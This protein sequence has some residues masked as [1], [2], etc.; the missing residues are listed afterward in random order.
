MANLSKYEKLLEQLQQREA[1]EAFVLAYN[2]Y[3]G[4]KGIPASTLN[5]ALLE[6]TNNGQEP[7]LLEAL[8][9]KLGISIEKRYRVFIAP[10]RTKAAKRMLKWAMLSI[11]IMGLLGFTY[12]GLNSVGKVPWKKYE[13]HYVL[14][15]TLYLRAE[16]AD[17]NFIDTL[18]YAQKVALDQID[19]V[20]N[21]VTIKTSPNSL[22][23]S[24]KGKVHGF[25]IVSEEDMVLYQSMLKRG[26]KDNLTINQSWMRRALI[27][28]FKEKNYIGSNMSTTDVERYHEGK[29]SLQRWSFSG[30]LSSAKDEGVMLYEQLRKW[31]KY[32][33]QH[34]KS[35]VRFGE[36]VVIKA[37]AD[38]PIEQF[39]A[40]VLKNEE[41]NQQ[42]LVIF[43]FDEEQRGS[44]VLGYD[45]PETETDFVIKVVRKGSREVRS[46]RPYVKEFDAIVCRSKNANNDQARLFYWNPE[47]ALFNVFETTI[48]AR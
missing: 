3:A 16:E 17:K 25:Y 12:Y 30:N 41:T 29:D 20:S 39:A 44:A 14:P 9:R 43:E 21:Y 23:N 2:K 27:D 1:F 34:Y 33:V 4:S 10:E 8:E 32:V 35:A 28:Y 13:Y 45:F 6:A 19:T 5:R 15:K 38:Q 36:K 48:P 31:S 26:E 42:R 46:F 47:T 24:K 40:Y 7:Q 11:A 22:F 37:N 18:H